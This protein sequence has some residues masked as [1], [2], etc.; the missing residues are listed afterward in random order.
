M[1]RDQLGEWVEYTEIKTFDSSW[2]QTTCTGK[3][4]MEVDLRDPKTSLQGQSITKPAPHGRATHYNSHQVWQLVPVAKPCSAL[5][6]PWC[7][8]MFPVIATKIAI[9]LFC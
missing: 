5:L 7:N 3:T 2:G 9:R 1:K 6:L 4:F 8:W